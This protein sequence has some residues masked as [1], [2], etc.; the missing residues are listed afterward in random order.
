M[1]TLCAQLPLEPP[2]I[3]ISSPGLSQVVDSRQNQP[4]NPRVFVQA[5]NA[6]LFQSIN[7][8]LSAVCRY[9]RV[10]RVTYELKDET[11]LIIKIPPPVV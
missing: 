2:E 6:S 8:L 1:C 5:K 7:F 3:G 9:I 10:E 4:H 11:T